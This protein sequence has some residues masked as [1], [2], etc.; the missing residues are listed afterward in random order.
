MTEKLLENGVVLRELRGGGEHEACVEL[1]RA[2][3]GGGFDELVP[4]AIL[5]ITQKIGGVVAG[6]FD[7]SGELLGFVYGMTG[8]RDGRVAHWSHMLAVVEESKGRGIG[9]ELKLFQRELLCTL[10]VEMM[11]WTYDPLV[12]RNANLNLNRLGATP[13]EYVRDMYGSSTGSTLHSGLGTDRFVV[14]WELGSADVRE[15]V[16]EAASRRKRA[17]AGPESGEMDRVVNSRLLSKRPIPEQ[18][19]LPAV[20]VVWV[21]V[22]SDIEQEKRERPE[23]AKLWRAT[24]RRAFEHYLTS[25]YTVRGMAVI[26]AETRRFLYRLE[27]P[28]FLR[29]RGP[30]LE[31]D[32]P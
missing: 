4:P 24:T 1:Q 30:T 28:N 8:V 11:F 18:R 9:R 16:E 22:P 26:D 12:A 19:A 21:E 23:E 6:A 17:A 7:P 13:Q 14:A 25:G 27:G 3:W 10:G 20:D 29:P 15:R 2:T 31:E 32:E 5:M